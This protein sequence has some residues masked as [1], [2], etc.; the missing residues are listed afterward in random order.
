MP[1][2]NWRP[3]V[4]SSNWYHHPIID[5][6]AIFALDNCSNRHGVQLDR[7]NDARV[8]VLQFLLSSVAIRSARVIAFVHAAL[9]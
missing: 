1:L 8:K 5:S 4:D 9:V 6:C 3:A 7:E 2:S